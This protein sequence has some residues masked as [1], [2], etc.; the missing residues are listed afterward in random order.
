[1][2]KII[3]IRDRLFMAVCLPSCC[4]KTE[5]LFQMLLRS[6]FYP[7]IKSIYYLYQHSQ[8]KFSSKERNLNFFSQSFLDLTSFHSWKTCRL[9][10]DNS[11]E[12]IVNDKEFSKP[13]TAGH[14]RNNRDLYVKHNFFQQSKWPRTIDQPTSIC[15]NHL[16]TYS[17]SPILANN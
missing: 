17:R 13:A 14:H 9:V 10:F 12:E 16:E 4:G 8:P 2:N 5:F 11:C 7:K 15:S 1:M 6:T 3:P